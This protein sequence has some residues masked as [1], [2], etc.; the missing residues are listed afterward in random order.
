MN[1]HD[2]LTDILN[3]KLS[4]PEQSTE[5]PARFVRVPGAGTRCPFTGLSHA[6]MYQL[7]D[8]AGPK[9]RTVSL[10]L[11]GQARGTRLIWLPDV[12]AY[13]H[14]LASK[15]NG[16][17]AGGPAPVLQASAPVHAEQLAPA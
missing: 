17:V 3:P 2:P 8:N 4:T 7:L 9:I 15:G 11:P 14:N 10:A 16:S 13:L 1:T 5:A 6:G 12:F